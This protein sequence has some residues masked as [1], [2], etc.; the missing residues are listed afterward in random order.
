MSGKMDEFSKSQ[1]NVRLVK[2]QK[3]E[4]LKGF[5]A[6]TRENHSRAEKVR[7]KIGWRQAVI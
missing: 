2:R 7:L 3:W 4:I 1:R 6:R 5:V